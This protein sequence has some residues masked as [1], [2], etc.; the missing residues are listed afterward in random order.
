RY[1]ERAVNGRRAAGG[2]MRRWL[3][4]AAACALGVLCAGCGDPVRAQ[5]IEQLGPEAIDVA[6]GPLH[7]PGQPCLV[8]HDGEDSDVK[9]YSVA[10]TVYLDTASQLAAA[11]VQVDL[12]DA[13]GR[14]HTL[15]SNCAGNFYV[16]SGVF[17]PSYPLWTALRFDD[18]RIAMQS[19]I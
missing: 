8:C 19:P 9:R 11:N 6:A 14:M 3:C 10:G 1:A 4:E 5:R 7:R 17:E 18:Y 16:E 2:G 12:L 15:T 13:R